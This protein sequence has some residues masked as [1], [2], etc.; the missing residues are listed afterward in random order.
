MTS[1]VDRYIEAL[2]AHKAVEGGTIP[3]S[4]GGPSQFVN[5][6]V[7]ADP[8]NATDVETVATWFGGDL[9]K[10]EAAIRANRA[11]VQTQDLYALSWRAGG[12][13]GPANALFEGLPRHQQVAEYQRAAGVPR[14]ELNPGLSLEKAKAIYDAN[15]DGP[16]SY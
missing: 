15:P 4:F 5:E 11:T 16:P 1:A 3:R 10:A 8:D 13:I 7:T 6:L 2:N 12:P 9:A 14:T